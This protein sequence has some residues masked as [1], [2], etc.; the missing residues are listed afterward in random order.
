MR[1]VV[2]IRAEHAGDCRRSET[3]RTGTDRPDATLRWRSSPTS[4]G[5]AD[6]RRPL[7]AT[8]PRPGHPFGWIRR[9]APPPGRNRLPGVVV[10]K[11]RRESIFTKYFGLGR[12]RHADDHGLHSSA[13]GTRFESARQGGAEDA[14]TKRPT[15]SAGKAGF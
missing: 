8:S 1:R 6:V 10:R 4:Q 5:I 2:D 3:T 9:T 13:A 15:G 11:V 12:A 14:H 7:S